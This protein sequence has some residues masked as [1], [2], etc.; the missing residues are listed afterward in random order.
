MV[1]LTFPKNELTI[2]D[3]VVFTNVSILRLTGV[4]VVPMIAHDTRT[5]RL[6][7]ATT[8]LGEQSPREQASNTIVDSPVLFHWNALLSVGPIFPAG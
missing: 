1:A 4:P 6:E 8:E 7:R 2:L 5:E 3:G